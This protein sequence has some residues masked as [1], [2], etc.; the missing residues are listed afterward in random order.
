MVKLTFYLLIPLI[1]LA[2]FDNSKLIRSG[3]A[4]LLRLV[5]EIK[6]KLTTGAALFLE[7][8]IYGSVSDKKYP[9]PHDSLFLCSLLSETMLKILY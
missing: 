9:T 5:I 1:L 8:E 3:F 4:Q 7:S 6:T 2:L